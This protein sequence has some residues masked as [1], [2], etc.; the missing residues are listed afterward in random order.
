MKIGI[1]GGAFDPPHLGHMACVVNALNS[2]LVEKV[3]IVPS[4]SSRYDKTSM[5]SPEARYQMLIA[6]IGDSLVGLPVE[7][8]RVQ[9]D[10]IVEGSTYELAQHFSKTFPDDIIKILICTD[11][12][13]A[14]PRWKNAN[15]LIE[16]YSFIAVP[17]LGYS[18]IKTN[19]KVEFINEKD[20]FCYSYSSA[21]VREKLKHQE[22]VFSAMT[23]S[24]IKLLE[25]NTKT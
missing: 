16:K 11:L 24:A 23:P 7:V 6:T 15:L 18:A 14:L 25:L 21:Q 19:A 9:I 22:L 10:E 13:D 3:I 2:K 12:V 1:F 5:F 8:S 17:R 4:G 20:C